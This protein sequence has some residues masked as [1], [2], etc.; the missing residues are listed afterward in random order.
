MEF[1]KAYSRREFVRFLQNSFLPEDFVPSEEEVWFNTKMIYSTEAVKLGTCQSLELVVYEVKHQSKHDARVSLSKEAFRMLADEMKDRALVIFVP[2][3][4]NE[5]YRFSLIEITLDEAD[6]SA[7]G[8]KRYSNPRRYSYLVGTSLQGKRTIDEYLLCKKSEDDEIKR[9]VD[10]KDLRN[11]FSV[12]KLTTDF[13]KELQNW[14][15]CALDVVR[16]PNDLD[17]PNDDDKYNAESTIRLITR[18]IFVWFLKQKGLIPNEF[19]D[20]KYIADNLLKDFSPNEQ[21]GFFKEK[22]LESKYYKAILQNLFFAMLNSPITKEGKSE[23]S[24]RHFRRLTDKGTPSSSDFNDNKLMRYESMFKNPQLFIDL[25]NQTVPFLNG[26]LF[27][28]LDNKK[29]KFYLDGFSDKAEVKKALVVPDYLFFSDNIVAD[30]STFFN[31]KKK[32][33]EHVTGIIKIFGR[34]NFTI[35][36][37]T[38]FDQE[39]SLDPELL[40]KVFENLL[41]SY[42]PETH[43]TAR[44][45]TGSFYTPREIVQYMVDESLVA[46]LKQVVGN[47]LEEEYRKLLRYTDE[48]L[49]LT[50]EQKYS[51]MNAI[52]NCKVLDPACGSGAFPVGMLQQMVHV[53]SQLDP[54]NDVWQQMVL[55]EA[56]K[57][58]HNAFLAET[59]EEREQRLKEINETFEDQLKNP[60]Y[61][62]KLYLIENCLYGVDIQSIAI[63]ICKLR[64][65]ISLV[66]DQKTNNKPEDNFGIRPLPNHEAKFVAANTLI[67]LNKKNDF[68]LFD[69]GKV[70]EKM[71]QMKDI[72]HKIFYLKHKAKEKY[73]DKIKELKCEIA[74]LLIKN[75][76]I[77]NDEAMQIQTWDRF[78][79]NSFAPFFDSEWM[80]GVKDGFDIIIGN[81]PY[82]DAKEQLKK[83]ELKKQRE[84]LSKDKRYKT[85]YQKWDL[86]IAFMEISIRYFCKDDG[87]FTM[88][89][90]YPLSNQL[91]AKK[92]RKMITEEYDLLEI[93]DL[94]NVKVFDNAT[95]TNCIP[96]VRKSHSVTEF[97]VSHADKDKNITRSYSKSLEHLIQDC[98]TYIWNFTL[99]DR[100]ANRHPD[101]YVLGD[102]CYISKGMVLNSDEKKAKGKFKKEDLISNACDSI[103]CKQYIEGKDIEPY[104]IKRVRFLEWGTKRSPNE[105]SR[106]TFEELYT[107]KKLLINALGQ[108]KVSIDLNGEF[109]CEQQVRMALLWKDL[110]NVS[111]KSITSSIQKFSKLKRSEMEGLSRKVDLLYLLG[112][113]NSKYAS[114]LLTDIRS[115]DYHIVPEHIRNI[116]IALVG[117]EQQQPIIEFVN[118]ILAAKQLDPNADTSLEEH[119]IDKLVYHFYGLTYDEILDVDPQTKVTRYEY[120]FIR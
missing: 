75:G 85:L 50:D 76:S 31:D 117:K 56:V 70:K 48:E 40:G 64:F 98:N 49:T 107:N 30:L 55:N 108:L 118:S 106:P 24:E 91:Y 9:V 97:V 11:R 65:F 67:G 115:G 63:Q 96:F 16:F 58:S 10:Y 1:N 18:L 27:D 119:E 69:D 114:I 4:S 113:L 82:I 46:H 83:E 95:V 13:Y 81:P 88:I 29:E 93:V 17:D 87:I 19:F 45:Q 36:E 100:N 15:A 60:D 44:K 73:K 66:V 26:G 43:T 41:A 37:N 68:P 103:H 94:Y 57:E 110:K 84:K 7:R 62:R 38:P 53:L 72:N 47:E 89:V 28:C 79:Q 111:N 54:S 116:P 112:I 92:M 51:I 20:E 120:E 52:Y 101:M 42:N 71:Q 102:F 3:D 6:D 5:N 74:D 109:Y 80:F 78:D 90:P 12:E 104:N 34:Y 77:G 61:K 33:N 22:S 14:F 2:E 59:F 99:E 32:Y 86:Y 105:L 21:F 8:T 35:E 23:L 25:A 39:V